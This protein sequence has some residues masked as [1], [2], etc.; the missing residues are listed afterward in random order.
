MYR[1]W[2]LSSLSLLAFFSA[3]GQISIEDCYEK[4]RVNYPLIK[5]YGL[6]ERARD[7]NLSNVSKAWMPQAQLSAKATYQS[8]VTEIP[9]D[10]SKL[11]IPGVSIPSLDKDQ[12]GATLEISQTI[13]DGG[14]VDAKRKGIRA[15]SEAEDRELDVNLYAVRE[16]VNQLFFGILLCEAMLEQNRLFQD[17]LQVNY[18]RIKN[19]MQ[20]GLANQAD[21]DAVRVEQLKAKQVFTQISHERKAYIAMLS[22]FIGENPDENIRLQKPIAKQVAPDIKR[23][24]LSLFDANLKSLDAA[25]SELDANLRPKFGLFLTGG[26]GKPGLNMLKTEFSAYYIGGVRLTWNLGSFYTRKNSLNLLESNRNAIQTQRETFLFNTVLSKT[27][28]ENEIDKYR[29][30]LQSDDEIISLRNSVR[31]AA[32][33]K[34]ENGTLTVTDLMHEAIAEQLARQDKILHEIE[35]LQAIYNLKFITNN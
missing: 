25:K 10:F 34:V 16:R 22:V 20:G 21:L 14:T 1:K 11:G 27:K 13:W 26:Y 5:Q 33:S 35:W 30:L 29:E 9:I 17:E 2:I 24:E 15:K 28:K 8:E 4:A 32:E 12:Y 31:R 3:F 19:L 6:I 23:P 7:Y 18:D